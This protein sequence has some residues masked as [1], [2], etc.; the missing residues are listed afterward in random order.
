MKKHLLAFNA[1]K[2]M[3][4]SALALITAGVIY[5]CNKQADKISRRNPADEAQGLQK[6]KDAAEAYYKANGHI[7]TV[8][9]NQ[10][11][12]ASWLSSRGE[13]V[14]HSNTSGLVSECDYSNT[15]TVTLTGYTITAKCY[16]ASGVTGPYASTEYQLSWTYKISSVISLVSSKNGT[17]DPQFV[18]IYNAAGTT[19]VTTYSNTTNPPNAPVK[20]T[21]AGADGSNP[22]YEFFNVTFTSPWITN[23]AYFNPANYLIKVSGTVFSDCSDGE[24]IGL[25]LAPYAATEVNPVSSPTVRVDANAVVPFPNNGTTTNTYISLTAQDAVSNPCDGGFVFPTVY[26]I[27]FSFDGVTWS[28]DNGIYPGTT[29]KYLTKSTAPTVKTANCLPWET[30]KLWLPTATYTSIYFRWRNIVFNSGISNTAAPAPGTNCTAGP[31]APVNTTFVNS[32]FGYQ[33]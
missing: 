21:D 20:I 29:T 23:A 32:N 28:A 11:I 30:M 10:K 8:P 16:N 19:L 31:W 7:Y 14:T 12:E 4:G 3:T 9:V 24:M 1:R 15:P 27:E 5:S 25:N 26:E 6:A 13:K 17:Q 22:G 33:N 18:K 2:L